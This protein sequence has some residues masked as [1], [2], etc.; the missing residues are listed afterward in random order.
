MRIALEWGM[1]V[2]LKL[3]KSMFSYQF[4]KLLKSN[5]KADV[6]DI[7]SLS[8]HMQRDI[9]VTNEQHLTS[10]YLRFK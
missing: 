10:D 4:G 3:G 8:E 7:V 9:G 1:N 2:E 5:D 6:V